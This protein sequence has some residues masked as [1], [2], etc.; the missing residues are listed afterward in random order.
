MGLALAGNLG[1]GSPPSGVQG[2]SPGGGLEAKPL[3]AR[4]MLRHEDEKTTYGE[5]KQVHTG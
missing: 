4:R 1:D 5:K 2:Q 3:E